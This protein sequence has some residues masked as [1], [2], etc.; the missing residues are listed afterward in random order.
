MKFAN[1]PK[2]GIVIGVNAHQ[3]AYVF[4]D[5]GRLTEDRLHHHLDL[6]LENAY[7]EHKLIRVPVGQ[8]VA[9]FFR[10]GARENVA[11]AALGTATPPEPTGTICLVCREPQYMTPSG[12]TCP[13]GHGGA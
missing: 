9:E 3:A 13:N 4:E 6:V 12:V 1:V 2:F 11:S 10:V 8:D 5:V 7:G